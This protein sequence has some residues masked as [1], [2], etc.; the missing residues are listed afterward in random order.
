M[1]PAVCGLALAIE[2]WAI[3]RGIRFRHGFA[4]GWLVLAG[5]VWS[6]FKPESYAATV[7]HGKNLWM[8]SYLRTHDLN[9]ANQ[10]ADFSVYS[11]A[12]TS[13]ALA[14]RL[15]WLEEQRLS[16]FRIPPGQQ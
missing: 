11:P 13:P 2:G 10:A 4:L 6:N 16:F 14:G 15:R 8:A 5:L 7:A 9:A 1:M 3:P 12:P